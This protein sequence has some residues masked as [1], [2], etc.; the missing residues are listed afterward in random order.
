MPHR[1]ATG[2]TPPVVDAVHVIDVAAGTPAHEIDK[3]SALAIAG[4]SA[5]RGIA[6]RSDAEMIRNCIMTVD[7]SD[8]E[9]LTPRNHRRRTERRLTLRE[10]PATFYGKRQYTSFAFSRR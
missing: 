9:R 6:A 8:N 7:T 3:A 1:S 10:R 4:A 5:S 2:A